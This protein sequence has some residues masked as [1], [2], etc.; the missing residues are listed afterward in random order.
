MCPCCNISRKRWAGFPRGGWRPWPTQRSFPLPPALFPFFFISNLHF[1][2]LVR[3]QEALGFLS[4]AFNWRDV[5]TTL[6]TV[7]GKER[8]HTHPPEGMTLPLTLR[9]LPVWPPFSSEPHGL[10]QGCTMEATPV[11]KPILSALKFGLALY[12]PHAHLSDNV[13]W[14]SVGKIVVKL[15]SANATSPKILRLWNFFSQFQEHVWY[16]CLKLLS[17][18]HC[19]TDST[20]IS[21]ATHVLKWRMVCWVALYKPNTLE[22]SRGGADYLLQT[23]CVQW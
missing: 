4:R 1:A 6:V 16:G 17:M 3:Q 19:D 23:Q 21:I 12:L 2:A 22:I 15:R 7:A 14:S 11:F 5:L 18:N 10:Y 8:K 13:F 9:A 20:G